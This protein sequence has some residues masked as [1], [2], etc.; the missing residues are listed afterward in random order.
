[1][2]REKDKETEPKKNGPKVH[3]KKNKDFLEHFSP[4][5][6]TLGRDRAL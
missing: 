1:M 5:Q 4:R 6:K 2:S 3:F